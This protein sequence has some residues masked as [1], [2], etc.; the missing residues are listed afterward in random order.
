MFNTPAK[1]LVFN[2]FLFSFQGPSRRFSHAGFGQ[3]PA[4]IQQQHGVNFSSGN[5][6]GAAPVRKISL[7]HNMKFQPIAEEQAP[8]R[9]RGGKENGQGTLLTIHY[10]MTLHYILCRFPDAIPES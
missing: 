5:G 7:H 4:Q 10:I 1:A 9:Q 6:A 8:M 3:Q 2:H